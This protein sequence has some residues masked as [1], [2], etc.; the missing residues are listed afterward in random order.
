M[1]KWSL[2][3]LFT[4]LEV[5]VENGFDFKPLV[6]GISYK[7]LLLFF[8]IPGI[9]FITANPDGR[10]QL[11]YI[12]KIISRNIVFI[13][14]ITISTVISYSFSF[15]KHYDLLNSLRLIKSSALDPFLFFCIFFFYLKDKKSTLWLIN[16]F[17]LLVSISGLITLMDAVFPA[18]SLF[19]LDDDS[20]RPNGLMG[21]PNISAAVLALFIAPLIS[22]AIGSKK[23][24]HRYAVLAICSLIGLIITGSRGGMLATSAGIM[25]LL[26]SIRTDVGFDKKIMIPIFSVL[27]SCIIWFALPEYYQS[28]VIDRFSVFG[29]KK[30]DWGHASAGRLHLLEIGLKSWADSPV[31]GYGWDGFR[32]MVKSASHNDYLNVLFNGGIFALIFYLLIFLN[33]AKILSKANYIAIGNDYFLLKGVR[34]GFTALLISL[35]FVNLLN[36]G[37]LVWSFLGVVAKFCFLTEK[38]NRKDRILTNK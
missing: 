23:Y 2:L 28:L 12:K 35:L 27:A 20:A 24:K 8:L 17:F 37:V 7:T 6:V 33:Y 36:A 15:L 26:F 10:S 19:G 18:I 4:F 14:L 22:L 13:L 1:N 11:N 5:I 34:A 31:I 29:Q 30:I 38:D 9:F 21:E 32:T 3:L 16:A 25:L